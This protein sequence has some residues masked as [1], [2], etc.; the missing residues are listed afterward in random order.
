MGKSVPASKRLQ[1][2]KSRNWSLIRD[3]NLSYLLEHRSIHSDDVLMW[4]YYAGR[5]P[6]SLQCP[7]DD[8]AGPGVPDPVVSLFLGLE[9]SWTMHP[10][11]QIKAISSTVQVSTV[12]AAVYR[13]QLHAPP[14]AYGYTYT[15]T[16]YARWAVSIWDTVKFISPSLLSDRF[17]TVCAGR[18]LCLDLTGDKSWA[19][20]SL[21]Y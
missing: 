18:P 21:K 16:R 14:I 15:R 7:V 13:T 12:T 2:T 11:S 19:L 4:T 20:F 17:R 6:P 5:R 9:T 1:P 10:N 8:G 3:H